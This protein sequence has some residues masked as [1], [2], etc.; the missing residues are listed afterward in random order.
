MQHCSKHKCPCA[1]MI[2][3][4]DLVRLVHHGRRQCV[5]SKKFLQVTNAQGRKAHL[6]TNQHCVTVSAIANDTS[7]SLADEEGRRFYYFI[8]TEPSVAAKNHQEASP[9]SCGL[10]VWECD[11]C[12]HCWR[13]ISLSA[14]AKQRLPQLQHGDISILFAQ[15]KEIIENKPLH[16][17]LGGAGA[18]GIC[19]QG[20]N[21]SGTPY[22]LDSTPHQMAQVAV[23][24][25]RGWDG[26]DKGK[27]S[28]E[29]PL[30][31]TKA[32]GDGIT[33]TSY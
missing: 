30:L 28:D 27:C 14:A 23:Q 10:H 26:V 21:T 18:L 9:S 31:S 20:A 15:L 13:W 29:F 17:V 22:L 5:V 12:L 1:D 7:W 4:G 8:T 32:P 24:W 25:P 3:A 11:Y 16:G 19:K 33:T 2:V 6:S